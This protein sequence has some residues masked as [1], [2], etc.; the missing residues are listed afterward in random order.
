MALWSRSP[1]TRVYF[2]NLAWC[3]FISTSLGNI[4]DQ[5][6]VW[7]WFMFMIVFDGSFEC[8]VCGHFVLKASYA[9][10]WVIIS[11]PEF[12]GFLLRP[13]P[14]ETFWS[15]VV[16]FGLTYFRVCSPE[17]PPTS[18]RRLSCGHFSIGQMFVSRD[19]KHNAG[20]FIQTSRHGFG[21]T[22]MLTPQREH[23]CGSLMFCVSIRRQQKLVIEPEQP[24]ADA[25]CSK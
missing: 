24:D 11:L 5:Q 4:T 21:W 3:N 10:A 16:L 18:A 6:D 22:N 1:W 23:L 7:R 25:K 14:E 13:E 9:R 8:L 17:E 12:G 19:E 15:C 2:Y 20:F